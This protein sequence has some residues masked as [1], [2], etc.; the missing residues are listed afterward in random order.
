[1]KGNGIL[2]GMNNLF[3]P[4][5]LFVPIAIWASFTGISP[6]VLFF[7]CALAIVPLAKFIG[8]ATEEL[9]TRTS[10]AV[11]GLLSATFGNATELI[12]GLL[13]LHAGLIDVVKA[14][15]TGSIIGNLLLVLGLAMFAGGWKR[16]KQTFNKTGV[17]AGG[18]TL[19]LGTVALVMPA[20]FF[21]TAPGVSA[22]VVENL[23][24]W[25]AL[26]LIVMYGAN[27]LFSLHTHKHLYFEEAGKYEPRWSLG[28]AVLTLLA[29]TLA[30]AWVSDILVGSINPLVTQLGWSQLFVGVIFIAIIGNA[31]ENF[32]AILVALK[33]RMDLSLQITIGSATQIGMCVAP[34]LVF[35]SL[36]LGQ[37]MNLVFNTFELMAMVLAV[38]IVN[39]ILQDGES[40]WLEGA[41]LLAAYV[42]M[43]IAFFFHP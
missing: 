21:Q 42:I 39:F 27:L 2:I 17:L 34:I 43:G 35:A 4:L 28:Q 36:F 3:V 16:E 41:Q 19:L 31:A 13:A 30:V 25:V 33:N 12:I 23:S 10:P 32:S 18:S 29:S 8:E 26:V 15:I 9:A 24:V 1:M 6:V 38:F 20:I 22:P 7:L 11:G 14:S 37:P 40:N 5:L